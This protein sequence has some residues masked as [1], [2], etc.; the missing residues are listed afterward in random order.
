MNK[1]DKILIFGSEGMVGACILRKLKE[2]GYKNLLIP[3]IKQLDLTNQNKVTEY[4]YNNEPDY[5]FFLAARV[6]RTSFYSR[7][8]RN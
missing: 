8:Q 2:L 6:V 7:W 4:F 3:T 5:V 1:T